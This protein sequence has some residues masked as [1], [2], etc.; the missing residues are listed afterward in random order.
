MG[1]M[2]GGIITSA[3]LNLINMQN[4]KTFIPKMHP[5]KVRTALALSGTSEGVS[6]WATKIPRVFVFSETPPP[7]RDAIKWVPAKPA[8]QVAA[9]LQ[10][11]LG[12]EIYHAVHR[13]EACLIGDAKH[14]VNPNNPQILG[15]VEGNSM[16]MA[17]ACCA[18][19]NP[20]DKVPAVFIVAIGVVPHILRDLSAPVSISSDWRLWLHTWLTKFMLPHRYFDAT[21]LE[22]ITPKVEESILSPSDEVMN[23]YDLTE[24]QNPVKPKETP[25]AEPAKKK[26]GRPKKK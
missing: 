18:Y 22:L 1:T 21:D 26:P 17:W 16:E 23:A 7:V 13:S 2:F 9:A 15:K 19:E 4:V 3:R 25:Q 6:N 24:P 10:T 5:L 20:G 8:Y 11:F 12:N 14:D